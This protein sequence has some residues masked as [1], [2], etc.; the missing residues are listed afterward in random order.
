M[1]NAFTACL[2]LVAFA[3][4]LASAT[5]SDSKSSQQQ[6]LYLQAVAQQVAVN[7]LGGVADLTA[8]NEMQLALLASQSDSETLSA[9]QSN[10]ESFLLDQEEDAKT[11]L[12]ALF[13]GEFTQA[14]NIDFPNYNS[15]IP[16]KG[17]RDVY[18]FCPAG[19]E[20][21][22]PLSQT[23]AIVSGQPEY[24]WRWSRCS[25]GAAVR[26]QK[27]WVSNV[28]HGHPLL[29]FAFVE[30]GWNPGEPDK[31]VKLELDLNQVTAGKASEAEVLNVLK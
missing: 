13:A 11:S 3:S 29:T 10:P 17:V 19:A 2:I 18:T 1:K 21:Q 31:K 22:R 23:S 20:V 5:A 24:V 7:I 27:I 15:S 25:S 26:I 30:D 4:T 16:I 9:Q 6:Q 14:D 8:I 12:A 28:K